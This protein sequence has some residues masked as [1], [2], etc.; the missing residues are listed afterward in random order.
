[1]N[2]K[3]YSL[4]GEEFNFDDPEEAYERAVDDGLIEQGERLSLYEGEKEAQEHSNF[5]SIQ[6]F[7]EDMTSAAYDEGG[8]YAEDYIA[9]LESL[10]YSDLYKTIAAW[11][12]E[13]VPQPTFFLVRN[14]KEIWYDP[15]EKPSSPQSSADGVDPQQS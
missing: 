7:I 1:M 8:E 10:D 5:Y 9:E 14:S 4:N 15:N 13:H 12:D 11:F 6:S 2:E 3:V